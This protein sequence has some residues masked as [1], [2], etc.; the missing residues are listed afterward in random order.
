[1]I[2]IVGDV[3]AE[4]ELLHRK[5]ERFLPKDAIVIQV[6]DFGIWPN[7]KP[8][9]NGSTWLD[10]PI[11]FIKGNHEYHPYFA[12]ITE[13][14]ELWDRLIYVPNGSILEL[15]G[16]RIGFLGGGASPDYRWRTLGLDWFLDENATREEAQLLWDAPQVDALITHVPPKSVINSFF[17]PRL[18]FLINYGLPPDWEDPT[19]SKVEEVWRKHNRCRLF[20]GHMH[21]SKLCW[22]TI[23]I[24]N[25]LEFVEYA[26]LV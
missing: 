25:I 12:G 3:H 6:G 20:C 24:V 5:I 22:D 4:F 11:Y 7:E 18:P 14:T 16:Q 9:W 15:E 26:P 2:V 19:A 10:N 8:R 23:R 21:V 17:G 1:M 13:P